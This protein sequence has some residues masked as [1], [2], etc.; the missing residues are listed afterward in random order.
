MNTQENKIL[1]IPIH[2]IKPIVDIQEYSFYYFLGICFLAL[3][4]L[5]AIAFLIYK[6]LKQK[7]SYNVKKEHYKLIN[8]LDLTNTKESAYAI[9]LYGA[10]FKDDSDRHKE[11]YENIVDRLE[12]YKYKKDVGVFDKEILGYIEL[13]R[14]MLDV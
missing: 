7:N 6:Y 5:L 13:Y 14:G 4:F 12:V 10:T 1:D 3:A 2:D 11:M 9:T 8:E